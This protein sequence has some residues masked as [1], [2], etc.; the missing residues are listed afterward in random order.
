MSG[1][2]PPL[3]QYALMAACS[4][5]VQG[6]LY[7]YLCPLCYYKAIRARSVGIATRLRA[8]RPGFTSWQ[9]LEILLFTT[10]SKSAFGPTQPPIEWVSGPLSP[11]GKVAGA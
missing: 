4:I 7:L 5:E 9:G 10:A 2:I 8:G 6:Q 3:P 1:A 11:E